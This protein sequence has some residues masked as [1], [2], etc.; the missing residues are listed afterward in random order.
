MNNFPKNKPGIRFQVPLNGT[1]PRSEDFSQMNPDGFGNLRVD[2]KEMIGKLGENC[3]KNT[4]DLIESFGSV[5]EKAFVEVAEEIQ[6]VKEKIVQGVS[7]I[8]KKNKDLNENRQEIDREIRE[9]N[10]EK[11]EE[12]IKKIERIKDR[13]KMLQIKPAKRKGSAVN[14][15]KR[16]RPTAA[17]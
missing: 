4:N 15:S 11:S 12:I 14:N 1:Q 16:N 7:E 9:K 5:Q 2:L 8:E 6:L 10:N 3:V 17:K 13:L